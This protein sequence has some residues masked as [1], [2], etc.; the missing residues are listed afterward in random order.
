MACSM[1][2]YTDAGTMVCA[3]IIVVMAGT[4]ASII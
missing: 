2:V 3:N 4:M 1:A